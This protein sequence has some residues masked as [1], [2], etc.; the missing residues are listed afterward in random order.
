MAAKFD[1]FRTVRSSGVVP[2]VGDQPEISAPSEFLLVNL[3]E[4]LVALCLRVYA[5]PS[6]ARVSH[7]RTKNGDHEV[8]FIVEA[9]DH[10]VVAIEVKLS[11]DVNDSDVKHLHWLNSHLGTR[12]ADMVVI[13]TGKHAYRRKDG[14]A[15]VPLALLGV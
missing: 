6:M 10:R 12:L 11:P 13:T 3:F 9:P 1:T 2:T 4:S 8:D 15:V 5:Q 7:L 14:I